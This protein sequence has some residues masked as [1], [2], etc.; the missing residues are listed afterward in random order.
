MLC[1]LRCLRETH[2]LKERKV[3]EGEWVAVQGWTEP[4]PPFEHLLLTQ[5]LLVSWLLTSDHGLGVQIKMQSTLGRTTSCNLHL[6]LCHSTRFLAQ[7]GYTRKCYLEIQFHICGN[8]RI[9]IY[10]YICYLPPPRYPG[11]GLV[12]MCFDRGSRQEEQLRFAHWETRGRRFASLKKDA[13]DVTHALFQW[14]FHTKFNSHIFPHKPCLLSKALPQITHISSH[15]QTMPCF[16]D[17]S[18]E[19]SHI[20]SPNTC[21]FTFLLSM[22]QR[23]HM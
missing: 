21:L 12:Q 2:P 23:Q 15:T 22:K 18:T 14:L 11:L 8:I 9:Y 6:H 16:K 17:S 13:L 20:L 1:W 5:V 10:I 7:P 3:L 4:L 19:N